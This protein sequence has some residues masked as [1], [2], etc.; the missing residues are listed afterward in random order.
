MT[1]LLGLKPPGLSPQ[2]DATVD[3]IHD[4]ID[5]GSCTAGET[6]VSAALREVRAFEPASG[7]T[8]G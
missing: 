5:T 1:R 6:G 8:S 4:G 7:A 3:R 2:F